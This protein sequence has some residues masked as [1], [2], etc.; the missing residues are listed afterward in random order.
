MP[1]RNS[2]QNTEEMFT[3]ARN[4]WESRQIRGKLKC[5]GEREKERELHWVISLWFTR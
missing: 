3:N 1:N 4:I 5:Q 2:T